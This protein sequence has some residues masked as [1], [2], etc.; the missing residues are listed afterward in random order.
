MLFTSD[1][2]QRKMELTIQSGFWLSASKHSTYGYPNATIIEASLRRD[3]WSHANRI[4][5]GGRRRRRIGQRCLSWKSIRYNKKILFLHLTLWYP[6][7]QDPAVLSQ[8]V[9]VYT[10]RGNWRYL[11]ICLLHVV[12]CRSFDRKISPT[13][14]EPATYGG[15]LKLML[16]A[17]PVYQ[18]PRTLWLT[19]EIF[20][21]L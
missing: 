7:K 5:Q 6:K 15:F 19:T 8:R 18:D 21:I 10:R 11:E 1:K 4:Y 14:V 3:P 13:K 17:M 12:S 2:K 9:T 20:H 16:S